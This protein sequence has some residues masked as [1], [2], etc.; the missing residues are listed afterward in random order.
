MIPAG[1]GVELD[2]KYVGSIVIGFKIDSLLS[3]IS[4]IL[5]NKDMESF[6]IDQNLDIIKSNLVNISQID[7]NDLKN[8]LEFIK[9]II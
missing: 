2:Q 4:N 3:K 1:I 6:I 8:S 5:S 7:L 9:K